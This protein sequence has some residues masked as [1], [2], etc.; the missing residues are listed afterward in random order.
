M[1]IRKQI[2]I[3]APADAAWAVLREVGD[4][5]SWASMVTHSE[6]TGN[7]KGEVRVCQTSLGKLTENILEHADDQRV[8]A[9]DAKS[10]SMP[11]FIKHLQNRWEITPINN[12]RCRVKMK[13]TVDIMFP[14]NVFPGPMVK[15]KFSQ[16]LGQVLEEFRYYIETGQASKKSKVL[17]RDAVVSQA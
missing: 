2:E 10:D 6:A 3:D 4:I 12:E 16:N 9:Y 17:A 11:F 8:L 13:A 15:L 14:F 7:A 5:S 1:E